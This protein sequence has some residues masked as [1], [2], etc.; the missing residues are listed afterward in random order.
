MCSF[1]VGQGSLC[2]KFKNPRLRQ[3]KRVNFSRFVQISFE[4]G[5]NTLAYGLR[6]NI[7]RTRAKRANIRANNNPCKSR[8]CEHRANTREKCEHLCEQKTLKKQVVRTSCETC[9]HLIQTPL[10]AEIS[11]KTPQVCPKICRFK[12]LTEN[13]TGLLKNLN[14]LF[15]D[16]QPPEFALKSA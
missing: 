15:S 3:S 14:I 5:R 12:F 9:E 2:K 6:A 10:L 8:L 13:R 7:V 4:S 16:R 11:P 1:S